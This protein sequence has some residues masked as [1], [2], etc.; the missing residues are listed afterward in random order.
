MSFDIGINFR[1]TNAGAFANIDGANETYCLGASD[2]Y[3]TTRA[4]FTFGWVSAHEAD[5]KGDRQAGNDR[6][7]AGINYA[8]NDG[9]PSQFKLDLP[10][11][12][13]STIHL[14]MGDG[15]YSK[16]Y[17]YVKIQDGVGGTNLVTIDDSN[18]TGSQHF[19]DATGTDYT[20]VTWP[21]SETGVA[22]SFTGTLLYLLLGSPGA[23]SA[24]TTLA[25]LRVVQ[26]GGAAVPPSAFWW[27][28]AYDLAGGFLKRTKEWV[29]RRLVLPTPG[30]S[31]R[32]A[33]ER[34]A[35]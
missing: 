23:Q 20:N 17:Q 32:L 24:Q 27:E 13:S 15:S 28:R 19:D 12:G 2:I 22:V 16:A 10:A 5:G 6:R 4:G 35:G 11:S 14:A 8:T 3:P 18:G 1:S 30:L 21:G 9:T 7:L 29:K 33:S 31:M 25:H 26:A 34:G